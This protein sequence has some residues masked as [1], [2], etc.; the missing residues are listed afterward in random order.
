M[1]RDLALH[2]GD[3][4][5]AEMHARYAETLSDEVVAE[6]VGRATP[7]QWEDAK[8]RAVLAG[9]VEPARPPAPSSGG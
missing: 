8:G 5:F 7:A 4:A 9:L 2:G 1:L 3:Q 6:A